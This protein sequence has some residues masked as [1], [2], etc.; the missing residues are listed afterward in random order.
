MWVDSVVDR[1]RRRQGAVRLIDGVP[2][3]DRRS[4]LALLPSAAVARWLETRRGD[5][6]G[7]LLDL[8]AGNQPFR[9][10]YSPLVERVIAVDIANAPGLDVLST[11]AKMPFRDATFDT[12]LCT[13]VLEHVENAEAAVDE[14]ARTLRPG[15]TLLMTVPFLYPTH[16]APHDF[17]RT[18]HHGLRSVL[19]RHGLVVDDISAQ[20][21]PFVLMAHYLIAALAQGIHLAASKLGRSGGLV[22]NVMTAALLAAPQEA[23]RS[24]VAFR[25][26]SA[27]RVASLGYMAAAHR[28]KDG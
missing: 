22:D 14:I 12:V 6:S 25:L 20:G 11:A 1:Q 26:T 3:A 9:Q 23:V 28:P 27:A 13:E 5:V 19:E 17:W 21:G 2:Y 15:G 16:E 18:T 4:T 8:G 24:K 7:V 10:W